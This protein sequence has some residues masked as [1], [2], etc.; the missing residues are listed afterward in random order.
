MKLHSLIIFTVLI[1]ASCTKFDSASTGSNDDIKKE[2]VSTI[3]PEM[4]GSNYTFIALGKYAN[5]PTEE[6]WFSDVKT[7]VTHYHQYVHTVKEQLDAIIANG[8]KK[9]AIVVWFGGPGL[10][11]ETWGHTVCPQNGKLPHVVKENLENL[12]K[13]ISNRAFSEV[14]IRFGG[15]GQ[16]DIF[17]W[18]SFKPEIYESNKS[19]ISNAILVS[20]QALENK[21][22]KVYYDLGLELMGH[23]FVN[24]K[25]WVKEYLTKLWDYYIQNFDV[26]KTIGFSFNH[27][28]MDATYTSL[29]IFDDSGVRPPILGFDIYTDRQQHLQNIKLA[30]L[31]RG[32][33]SEYPI[34]IQETYRNDATIA[35]EIHTAIKSLKLN[36]RTIMQWPLDQ[37]ATGHSNST[38]Y[39]F[40]HY[41]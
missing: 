10:S 6:N 28:H 22:I 12:L 37:N 36:I 39:S 20:E 11:C 29:K 40:D 4:G 3:T 1:S 21:K 7:P 24:D 38:D 32:W 26:K 23:P 18:D 17:A 31:L 33:D 9:I 35:E 19:F 30:L 15:Q 14:Q 25:P 27:A 16:A 41:K 34:Y 5:E 2:E 8:Q 13:E